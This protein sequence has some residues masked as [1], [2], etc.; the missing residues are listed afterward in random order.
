MGDVTPPALLA[1]VKSAH[2]S[3]IDKTDCVS[4]VMRTLTQ[5]RVSHKPRA[6]SPRHVLLLQPLQRNWVP[7][8]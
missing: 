6:V 1:H 8:L 2:R 7:Q 3:V 5:E 4:A